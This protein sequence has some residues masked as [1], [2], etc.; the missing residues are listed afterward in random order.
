MAARL[1]KGSSVS[2]EEFYDSVDFIPE[3]HTRTET[4]GPRDVVDDLDN[5]VFL[6]GEGA[7]TEKGAEEVVDC[8]MHPAADAG[9]VATENDGL[10]AGKAVGQPE[11][12]NLAALETKN[13]NKNKDIKEKK[14]KKKGNAQDR[15]NKLNNNA[16]ENSAASE[17]LASAS[18]SDP[19][20]H[21]PSKKMTKKNSMLKWSAA[22]REVINTAMSQDDADHNRRSSSGSSTSSVER[23]ISGSA[24]LEDI[25]QGNLASWDAETCVAL[26]RMPTV[27]NYSGLKKLMEVA[28]EDWL[29]DFL[30]LDGL[31]VLFESLERLSDRGFSSIA[32]AILQLECVLCVKTVMNSTS[33]LEYIINNDDY[34]R[35]L[36]KSLDSRN[37]L[38][39][40]Q[41][42]ELLSALSVYS[43]KGHALALDALNNYKVFKNQRYRFRLVVEELASAEVMDYQATLLA[44]VNCIVLGVGSLQGRVAIR[45]E[46]I[47]LDFLKVLE[48]IKRID[49]EQLSIQVAAFEDNHLEDLELLYGPEGQLSLNHHDAFNNLFTKVRDSPH[50]LHL[51]SLLHNLL[52]LDPEDESSDAVWALLDRV[53]VRAVDGT[54]TPTWAES[55]APS[56]DFTRSVGTQTIKRRLFR[57]GDDKNVPEGFEERPFPSSSL[58]PAPDHPPPAPPSA[59]TATDGSPKSVEPTDAPCIES[60]SERRDVETVEANR[61]SNRAPPAPP[62]PPP[63]PLPSGIGGLPSPPPPPPPPP[64]LPGFGGPPPPPPLPG[65]G[66]PP[67]PPPLPGFGVPPPPP[68]PGFG[69]PPPPPPL[70]GFGG[71]PPP[72]P[73][74]G[75]GGPPPPPPFPGMGGPPPPPPLPGM[76][77]PPP[78]PPLPGMGG[79]PPPPPLPGMGGPPPPPPPPG[80]GGPPPPPLPGAGHPALITATSLPRYYSAARTT[81]SFYNTLPRPTQKMKHLN[82]AKVNGNVLNNSMWQDV[83]K[84]LQASPPK[85]LNFSQIEELFCQ[86]SKTPVQK[87][88]KKKSTEITL[89]DPKR[90]LNVNIF[91]KQFKQS[92]AEVA[93]LI[94]DCK[95]TDIGTERLRGFLRILPEDEEVSMIKDFNGDVE[96]LGNAERFY[97]ELI[98]VPHYQVRLQGM[99]QMEEVKPAVDELK[100]QI[101]MILKVSD[102]VL[103]SESIKEFFAYI[104]TV[105]NFIN[106]GSYAGNALGFRLNTV[107]KLWETRGN[108]PGM[109]LMHYLVQSAQD[110]DLEILDFTETLGDLSK[111]ARLSVDGLTG[112]VT[113]LRGDYTHLCKSLENAPD[114][115]KDRFKDF[116]ATSDGLLKDLEQSL[117]EV[118]RSRVKLAQYFCEDESKFKIGECIG[119]FNTLCLKI[120]DAR[121]DNEARKKREERKRRMEAERKR[122]EEERAKAEA[123]GVT[124]RKKGAPLPPPSDS[125]GCV[126][127]RLLA[128]IRK[129][130]FKLRKNPVSTAPA[131]TG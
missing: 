27:S 19:T 56:H 49:D 91:M 82:W 52:Q 33:G 73:L 89:L 80:M 65:F 71:P 96:K 6:E 69:G 81:P 99:I 108:R 104:L 12:T 26:L 125:G 7:S 28:G 72:P 123:A 13:N 67:P 31:G 40:K 90:S 45:N 36:A 102:Q 106:M 39:K 79:P 98:K 63:P 114:D 10:E 38:V 97:W 55:V 4:H 86:A 53:G 75:F 18:A 46:F 58:P 94:R 131:V 112:E 117:K 113:T 66:G 50:S 51:L 115:V 25:A 101:S 76:G 59:C 68:L 93:A 130:D 126:I 17:T 20:S 48:D 128:D 1:S 103:N 24:I 84:D 47:G 77:G 64:P 110:E 124:L 120:A 23:K 14:K 100:P 57:S 16:K 87:T 107:S 118:E 42:F 95:S 74:P 54:L 15:A 88:E 105:G 34:T 37:M 111:V 11:Y 116:V 2:D 9:R 22:A 127:D 70:P 35:K 29:E 60:L 44:F 85:A 119:I 129:G 5:A 32:D 30:N 83:H 43:E 41:V 8:A 109:T 61:E 122:V 62:P 3:T 78:P 92:H 121:K 21:P